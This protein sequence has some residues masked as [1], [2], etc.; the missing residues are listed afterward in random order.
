MYENRSYQRR[1]VVDAL[2]GNVGAPLWVGNPTMVMV[3]NYLD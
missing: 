1:Y 2:G 3:I